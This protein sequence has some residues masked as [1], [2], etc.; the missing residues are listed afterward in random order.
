[1]KMLTLSSTVLLEVEMETCQPAGRHRT[2]TAHV[3]PRLVQERHRH[4]SAGLQFPRAE[5]DE[6]T[7]GVPEVRLIEER[8]TIDHRG[9]VVT[10]SEHRRGSAC[11]LDLSGGR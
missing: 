9:P 2:L 3:R 1:M 11:A 4:G 7:Q 5:S 8:E 6:T 10:S